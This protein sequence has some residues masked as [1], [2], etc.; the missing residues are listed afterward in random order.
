VAEAI[1][2]LASAVLLATL[3]LTAIAGQLIYRR[4]RRRAPGG[5]GP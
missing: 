3:V 4:N 5:E 2:W 1:G